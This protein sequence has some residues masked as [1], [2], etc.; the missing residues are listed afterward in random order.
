VLACA[1]VGVAGGPCSRV[2][3]VARHVGMQ[4]ERGVG[5]RDVDL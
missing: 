3:G 2:G 5:R 1:V 4:L